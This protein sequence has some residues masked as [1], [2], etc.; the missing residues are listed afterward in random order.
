MIFSSAFDAIVPMLCVTL[1]ALAAM[2]A[3]AFRGRD[4][5]MPIGGLGIVGLVGAAIAA[6]LLRGIW[7]HVTG[8]AVFMT[9]PAAPVQADLEFLRTLAE[10]GELR[11]I[12]GRTYTLDQIEEAHRHAD[13]G[14][15]VGNLVVVVAGA[16][17]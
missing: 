7:A 12:I 3:E 8:R 1:A 14:H 2:G 13:T 6:A 4:E 17:Q 10:R 9:G 5:R 11:S 16:I 15:K